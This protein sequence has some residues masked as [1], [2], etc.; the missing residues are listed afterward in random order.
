[1]TPYAEQTTEALIAL[2]LTEEDRVTAAHIQELV[3]RPDATTPLC[4][5][6]ANEDYWYG[7][8]DGEWWVTMHA[9]SIL[10]L[11]RDPQ[12]LPSMINSLYLSWEVMNDWVTSIFSNALACLGEAAVTPLMD[13]ILTTRNNDLDDDNWSYARTDAARALTIIALEQPVSRARILQFLCDL[14]TGPEEEDGLFL[15]FILS[16]PIKLD[17]T[18]GLAAAQIAFARVVIDETIQGSYDS[19]VKDVARDGAAFGEPL[20]RDLWSFYQPEEIAR[21]QERWE[22]ERVEEA[23]RPA[24]GKGLRVGQDAMW[25]G[26]DYGDDSRELADTLGFGLPAHPPARP[27]SGLPDGY[28]RA[29]DGSLLKSANVGR[30]DP[31]PCGSGKKYK[32][33]CGK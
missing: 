26:W 31:C 5:I 9:L 23:N 24:A 13:Y 6:L 17:P 15:S 30:N 10:A 18:R 11:Q 29:A 21:R 22:R 8:E 2:L 27:P 4:E 20:D 14:L 1:M 25:R 32:K 3:M 33:C 28:T 12:A 16:Y 7:G 19:I